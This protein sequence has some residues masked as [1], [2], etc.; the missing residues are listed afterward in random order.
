VDRHQIVSVLRHARG[1]VLLAAV[2][3]TLGGASLNTAHA[4]QTAAGCVS[5]S[6]CLSKMTLA[7][8]AGQMTQVANTY[9]RNAQDIATYGIGSVLSGG[10]GGPNG[11][12]GGTASQCRCPRPPGADHERHAPAQR[13]VRE[14][15]AM[16]ERE[17]HTGEARGI[18]GMQ[19]SHDL[20]GLAQPCERL[21]L[22]ETE[23]VEPRTGREAEVRAPVRGKVERRDLTRDLDG[24]QGRG[25]ERGR[26][27]TYALGDARDRQ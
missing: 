16:G 23:L 15:R 4:A 1:V 19:T 2:A 13:L 5:T 11:Q 9:I 25:V 22:V 24:V 27:E 26:P 8:K 12:A 17:A 6:D 10:G 18:P 7:E 14:S 20:D 3:A 21:R